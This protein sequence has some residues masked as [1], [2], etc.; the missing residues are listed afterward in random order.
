MDA[1]QIPGV[2]ISPE[3]WGR[4]T[5]KTYR[6]G[7][8]EVLTHESHEKKG[9]RFGRNMFPNM[10]SKNQSFVTTQQEKA[11]RYNGVWRKRFSQ[12]PFVQKVRSLFL[13]QDLY[14]T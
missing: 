2:D 1:D 7:E 14:C 10:F 5:K 11:R 9:A 3:Q 4:K 12:K 6:C 13:L 8:A